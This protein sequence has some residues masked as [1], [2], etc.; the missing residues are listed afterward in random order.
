MNSGE[1]SEEPSVVPDGAAGEIGG[2]EAKVSREQ[3]KAQSRQRILDAARDVFFRDGFMSANLDE[4]AD[5]AGVAKGTLY[6]YFESKADLYVA[7]LAQ[8][9]DAFTD[10]LR[11]EANAGEATVIDDLRRMSR[12]YLDYW[13]RHPEYFQIFWAVDNQA[14]IGELPTPVMNEVSRLWEASLSVLDQLLQRAVEAGEI[15]PC[16]TWEASN[17]LWTVANGVIQ[18]EF[19]RARIELR[20][21]P[22]D[23]FFHRT[24]ELVI[25]GLRRGAP[26]AP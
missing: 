6:R 21:Q 24:I 1:R 10:R 7:I 17:I 8:N 12:F 23:Q 26:K 11:S 19:T 13:L 9:G 25:T 18:T 3:K 5:R 14:V 20:R 15:R 16:D 2:S 22:L 4:V